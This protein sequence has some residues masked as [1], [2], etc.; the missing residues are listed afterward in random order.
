M[1][2]AE[3][4]R[5]CEQL[6]AWLLALDA[7][8]HV[9]ERGPVPRLNDVSRENLQARAILGSA[10]EMLHQAATGSTADA[11]T[12]ESLTS[13][14]EQF[15][16]VA[17]GLRTEVDES[18]RSSIDLAD[19]VGDVDETRRGGSALEPAVGRAITGA[20]ARLTALLETV[21]GLDHRLA[22]TSVEL[23]LNAYGPNDGPSSGN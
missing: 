3:W 10:G 18:V 11:G 16:A 23:F 2:I 7:D 1:R 17:R 14:V 19:P 5:Q 12:L 4:H 8:N 22:E 6:G 13:V 21:P 9:R 15:S 20:C